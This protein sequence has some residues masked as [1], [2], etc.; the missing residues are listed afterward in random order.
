MSRKPKAEEFVAELATLDVRG[1]TLVRC[2]QP[3]DTIIARATEISDSV[4]QYEHKVSE[5]YI[6]ERV[7]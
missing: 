6:V 3:P 2:S 1:A 7:A 5:W 4:F